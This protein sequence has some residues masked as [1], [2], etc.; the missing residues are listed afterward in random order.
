MNCLT[1]VQLRPFNT[2][3]KFKCDTLLI[4]DSLTKRIIIICDQLDE[5]GVAANSS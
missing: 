2:S 5:I 1:T 3:A 4:T